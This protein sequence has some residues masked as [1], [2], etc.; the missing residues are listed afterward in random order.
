M[1]AHSWTFNISPRS[2]DVYGVA[3][4]EEQNKGKNTRDPE[5][6]QLTLYIDF[7]KPTSLQLYHVTCDPNWLSEIYL[8][9][10]FEALWK[11]GKG[12]HLFQ[13]LAQKPFDEVGR[14]N[15]TEFTDYWRI[16]FSI[17]LQKCNSTV[18]WKKM[19]RLKDA[20]N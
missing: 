13:K 8:Y 10:R 7:T 3:A 18:H 5:V 2:A 17:Q 16:R 9:T 19:F 20:L 12:S 1:L 15:P 11:M 4:Q 14:L 6:H